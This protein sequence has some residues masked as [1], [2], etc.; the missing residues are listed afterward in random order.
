VPPPSRAALDRINHVNTALMLVA[1]ALACALPFEV[2]LAAYA[3]LGP[4]HYLTQISWLHDRGFFTTGRFDW[5]P[6]ALLAAVAFVSVQTTWLPW[7]GAALTALAA[8]VTAAWARN[9]IAKLA[10]IVAAAAVAAPVQ[11]WTPAAVFFTTLLV[12]V[13]HVYVFT[14]VFILAGSLKNRSRSGFVSFGVYVACGAGLLLVHPAAGAYD[15]GPATRANV[16]SFATLIVPMTRFVPGA[17]GWTAI[18]AV[19]RF[20][21]F[22][23]TY[24]YLNWFSK[25]GVIRWHE[26]S[27]ARMAI[28]GVGWLLA[29]GLYAHD[30]ATGL[31][32]LY[33]LSVAHVFLEFPLDART[34]VDVAAG[35]G[36]LAVPR[37]APAPAPR[38]DRRRLGAAP[39]TTRLGRP[40]S[41]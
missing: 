2:F 39:R 36:R 22:A 17:R 32:A 4:L 29:L 25:T 1:T 16:Q 13:V 24:H 10:S 26:M 12:T 27:R 38:G 7:E 14:G 18:V 41:L 21:A 19:G 40:T 8:G 37:A 5:V 23:Y 31:M 11:S 30:Y 9:P 28:V 34:I 33:F 3:V 6:L 35:V 20:L 15:P